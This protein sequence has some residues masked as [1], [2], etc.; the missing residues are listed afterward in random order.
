MTER[1][2]KRSIV[3]DGGIWNDG[4]TLRIRFGEYK[5]N[6]ELETKAGDP[7]MP[8]VARALEKLVT[9]WANGH[10][11][12][13]NVNYGEA[14]HDAK[15]YETHCEEWETRKTQDLHSKATP[16]AVEEPPEEEA[17]F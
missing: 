6:V 9:G 3:V 10:C 15:P 17:A 2:S 1:T 12:T 5:D 7:N 11:S 16:P 4:I 8:E 13:L 14:I